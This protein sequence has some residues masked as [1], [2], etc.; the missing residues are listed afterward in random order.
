[1]MCECVQKTTIQDQGS[2]GDYCYP[3]AP[4]FYLPVFT[5]PYLR[6]DAGARKYY[7]Q[8]IGC[9]IVCSADP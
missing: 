1:M 2:G 4:L 7:L 9:F 3:F 6:H 8:F 5:F